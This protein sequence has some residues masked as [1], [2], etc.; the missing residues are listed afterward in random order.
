MTVYDRVNAGKERIENGESEI[1]NQLIDFCAKVCYYAQS[2][3]QDEEVWGPRNSSD[4]YNWMQHTSFT[5]ACFIAENTKH[6]QDGVEWETVQNE[7]I[8]P[9]LTLEQWR[10]IITRKFEADEKD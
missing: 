2:H 3:S 1:M 5:I 4:L 6:G 7:S 8:G 9:L 10:E